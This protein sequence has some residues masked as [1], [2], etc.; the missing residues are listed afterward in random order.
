MAKWR[1][2]R[3]RQLELNLPTWGGRRKGAGRKPRGRK[4]GV[5][6]R[7]RPE[8]KTD[9]VIHVTL[10]VRRDVARLRTKERVRVLRRCLVAGCTRPGFRVVYYSV[11]RLHLHLIIEADRCDALASG[12]NGLGSSMG[13][14][15]NATIARTGRVFVDRYHAHVLQTPREAR[16]ALAYVLLNRTRHMAQRG[17]RIVR[18]Q[19]DPFSSGALFDGWRESPCVSPAP[20]ERACVARPHSWL[21][22][23]GWRRHGFISVTEVPGPSRQPIASVPP[24]SGRPPVALL[25]RPRH[26]W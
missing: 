10:R 14:R 13:R 18:P 26:F 6:H 16:E 8:L 4:A 21:L 17:Q 22:R 1:R 7:R 3:Q 15:L 23:V 24:R 2:Q 19:P 25:A 20:P 11:Q 9:T 5:S 12:M